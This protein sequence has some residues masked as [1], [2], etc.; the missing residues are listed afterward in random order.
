[1][2]FFENFGARIMENRAPDRK[3]WFWKLW[4]VKWSFQKVLGV[5][6]EFLSGSKL[7]HE[8]TR[9]LVNTRNFRDFW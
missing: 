3:I 5:F 6:V 1:M 7:W 9:A 2:K 4:S 8:R